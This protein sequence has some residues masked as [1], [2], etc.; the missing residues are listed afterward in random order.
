MAADFEDIIKDVKGKDAKDLC[1]VLK[2]S[3][4]PMFCFDDANIGLEDTKESIDFINLDDKLKFNYNDAV[5]KVTKK[6]NLFVLSHIENA[7]NLLSTCVMDSTG[8]KLTKV[9][10]DYYSHHHKR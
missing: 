2:V 5:F 10:N 7:G 1:C 4:S 9:S 6:G 3:S 8:A